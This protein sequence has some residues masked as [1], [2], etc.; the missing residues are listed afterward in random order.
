MDSDYQKTGIDAY[1]VHLDEEVLVIPDVLALL[2]DNPMQSELACHIGLTARLFCRVCWVTRGEAA[3]DGDEEDDYL[4]ELDFASYA[5]PDDE[6]NDDGVDLDPRVTRAASDAPSTA[7][8]K[9]SVAE[10]IASGVQS[11][12]NE[13]KETLREMVSRVKRFVMVRTHMTPN[14]KLQTDCP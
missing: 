5:Y 6:D 9:S 14:F 12:D 8:E 13:P 1:D 4:P 3:D 7:S 10:S 2:G 11:V